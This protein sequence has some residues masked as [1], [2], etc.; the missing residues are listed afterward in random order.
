M[1]ISY[2][3][4]PGWP[5]PTEEEI[6]RSCLCH[7]SYLHKFLELYISQTKKSLNSRS[8]YQRCSIEKAVLKN[9]SIFAGK[10]GVS[11]QQ[12]RRS[13]ILLKETATQVFSC[14]YCE[15][16]ILR[17]PI[18]KKI[19]EQL[20]LEFLLL[21]DNVSSQG[22]VSALKLIVPLQGPFQGLK[23]SLQGTQWQVPLLFEKK[24]NQ[25]K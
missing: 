21:T 22:L 2:K 3:Y 16:F 15:I 7:T 19:F 13:A 23:S 1:E 9:F 8:C 5:E 25:P 24:K 17:T 18:L 12:S 10:V 11:F 6:I 20:P 14:E 4:L